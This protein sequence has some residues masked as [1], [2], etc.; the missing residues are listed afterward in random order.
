[1]LGQ[2]VIFDRV[3]YFYSD[4][5]DLGMECS[6]LPTPGAYDQVVYRGDPAS[7]EFVAFWLSADR[8]VAGMN[9][10]VWDVTDDIQSLIRSARPIDPARLSDPSTPLSEA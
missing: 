2:E 3:P 6:G 10:N 7:L 9:V 4:Q 5:Y 8:V 1:M